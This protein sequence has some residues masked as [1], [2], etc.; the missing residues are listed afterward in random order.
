MEA[1]DFNKDFLIGK[2][3]RHI[4]TEYRSKLGRF[5]TPKEAFAKYKKFKKIHLR[6]L[7]IKYKG[8]VEDSIFKALFEWDIYCG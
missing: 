7:A 5:S 1:L 8:K 6:Q 3:V 2:H 4:G